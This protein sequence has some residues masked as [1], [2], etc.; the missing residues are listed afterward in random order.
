[1]LHFLILERNGITII[2][3]GVITHSYFEVH[4]YKRFFL[5]I[6]SRLMA[7]IGMTLGTISLVYSVWSFIF[8]NPYRFILGGAGVVVFLSAMVFIK[9]L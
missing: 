8:H 1:M 4:E 5:I 2:N 7:G 6:I 9:F 3:Y